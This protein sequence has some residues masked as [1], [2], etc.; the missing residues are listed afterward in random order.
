MALKNE[1]HLRIAWRMNWD[2]H[3]QGVRSQFWMAVSKQTKSSTPINCHL[4]LRNCIR[5]MHK[6]LCARNVVGACLSHQMVNH[7][8]AN[9]VRATR[10]SL[11]SPASQMKRISSLP[12]Q[13]HADMADRSMSR[14][15]IVKAVV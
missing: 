15:F 8:H 12:W 2:M 13:L 1:R 9:I 14:S 11:R 3:V 6:D 5:Q 7:L 10:S 4:L